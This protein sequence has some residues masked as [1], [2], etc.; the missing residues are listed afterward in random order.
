MASVRQFHRY[1]GESSFTMPQFIAILREQLPQ[2]APSQTKYRVTEMPSERT[3]RF[4]TANGLVDKPL[5]KDGTNA[6]YGYR[7]LLQVM[8][9]KY[10]QS[11]YLPLVK[12][13]SLIENI[14]T[15]ELEHL[16]PEISPVTAAHRGIAREDRLV[17]ENS[18]RPQAFSFKSRDESHETT[19]AEA[20]SD[21]AAMPNTWRRVEIGPGIELHVH[22]AALPETDIERLRGALLREIGVLRGW[23]GE[24]EK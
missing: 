21:D 16:I 10:L 19:P 9:I 3:I 15:R 5:P 6:H 11:Q 23:F 20:P 13:K 14:S 7:H 8:A 22:A 1:R 12:V 18:F 17:V 4:Y 24:D 2:V